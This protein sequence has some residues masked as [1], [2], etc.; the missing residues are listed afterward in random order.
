MMVGIQSSS[1]FVRKPRSKITCLLDSHEFCGSI[2]RC[3]SLRGCTHSG[4]CDA[5]TLDELR[6]YRLLVDGD[7][8]AVVE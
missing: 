2:D 5:F 7:W 1:V 8:L 6:D 3:K 4:T